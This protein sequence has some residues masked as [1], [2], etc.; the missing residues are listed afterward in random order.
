MKAGNA[1]GIFLVT[2]VIAIGSVAAQEITPTPG[3]YELLEGKS[4]QFDARQKDAKVTAD[5]VEWQIVAGDGARLLNAN[6][7]R[8]TFVAPCDR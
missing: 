5:R 1:I 8:V 4:M 6:S 3:T 7:A 2:S